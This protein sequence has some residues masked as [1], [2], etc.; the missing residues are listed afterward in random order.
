MEAAAGP[1]VREVASK[2]DIFAI[3]ARI[4]IDR[5]DFPVEI[6]VPEA[7]VVDDLDLDSIDTLDLAVQLEE[8]MGFDLDEEMLKGVER[9]EDVVDVIH[10]RLGSASA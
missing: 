4:M 2:G 3:L 5:F 9:L 8:E 6:V 1:S 10:A 7:H